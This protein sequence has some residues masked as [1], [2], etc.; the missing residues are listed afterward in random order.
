[1]YKNKSR[2]NVK[3]YNTYR[4]IDVRKNCTCKDEKIVPSST[5]IWSMLRNQHGNENHTRQTDVSASTHR[6][7]PSFVLLMLLISAWNSTHVL[8]KCLMCRVR[9]CKA[10]HA[11][12]ATITKSKVILCSASSNI[13]CDI[14][15]AFYQRN[16]PHSV[17][18]K[19]KH[20]SDTIQHV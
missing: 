16:N 6:I 13:I 19:S 4:N 3:N 11:N 10:Y 15:K 14:I 8:N 9:T 1:M 5:A 12:L 7:R 20:L 18:I 17:L 2:N